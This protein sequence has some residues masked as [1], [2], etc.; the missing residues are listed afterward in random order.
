MYKSRIDFPSAI[1]VEYQFYLLLVF[2]IFK[3]SPLPIGNYALV[4]I[5]FLVVRMNFKRFLFLAQF[6]VIL[7]LY[8]MSPLQLA[9]TLIICIFEAIGIVGLGSLNELWCQSALVFS[10]LP[11][12]KCV[13]FHGGFTFLHH[14]FFINGNNNNTYLLGFLK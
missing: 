12:T 4:L 1:L 9:C 13:T 6:N 11:S 10:S 2:Q 3:C 7:K 5:F 8:K 14:N